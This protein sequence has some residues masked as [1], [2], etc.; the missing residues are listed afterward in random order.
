MMLRRMAWPL[1]LLAS[2]GACAA[3][4][5]SVPGYRIVWLIAIPLA[6]AA[7]GKL[8]GWMKTA[9]VLAVLI[10]IVLLLG[11]PMLAHSYK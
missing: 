3:W 5:M 7:I 6:A 11:L 9:V 4:A 10:D 1:V 2:S 8:L